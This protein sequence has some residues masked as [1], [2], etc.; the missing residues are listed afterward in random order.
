MGNG[1]TTAFGGFSLPLLIENEVPR[2][3]SHFSL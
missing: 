1:V 2:A 3:V